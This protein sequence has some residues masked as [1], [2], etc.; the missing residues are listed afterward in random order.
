MF[1]GARHDGRAPLLTAWL[2][3]WASAPNQKGLLALTPQTPTIVTSCQWTPNEPRR[4]PPLPL[5]YT[6]I[7]CF[8]APYLN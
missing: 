1:G 8:L 2:Q 4:T 6:E 5:Y 7:Y 3:H